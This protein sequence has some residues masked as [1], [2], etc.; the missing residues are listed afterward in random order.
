[1]DEFSSLL[2]T[3]LRLEKRPKGLGR[4]SP[5][6]DSPE[7]SS[8]KDSPET[9]MVAPP[10]S[11]MSYA[12]DPMNQTRDIIIAPAAPRAPKGL[13]KSHRAID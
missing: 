7:T 2:E 6:D 9:G 1:M 4:E 12:S 8:G 13:G 3:T 5:E 11:E 10:P